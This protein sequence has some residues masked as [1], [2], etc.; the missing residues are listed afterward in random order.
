MDQL[1]NKMNRFAELFKAL[2]GKVIQ[3][4]NPEYNVNNTEKT[5]RN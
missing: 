2:R 4:T 3:N 1:P 5:G